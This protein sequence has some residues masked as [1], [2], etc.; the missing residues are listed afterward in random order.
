VEAKPE[1][2]PDFPAEEEFPFNAAVWTLREEIP[3]PELA[4]P[5]SF[6]PPW[7]E[8]EEDETSENAVFSP[9]LA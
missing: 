6:V 7:L 3:A 2:V 1:E 5:N 4:T 8:P 9:A